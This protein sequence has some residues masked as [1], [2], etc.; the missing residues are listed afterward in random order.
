MASEVKQK[1][2]VIMPFSET[3]EK[4]TEDYWTN[5]YEK[6]LKPLIESG[7]PLI[8][9]RSSPLR[10]DILR[11]II[12][13][14]V[15]APIVVADLTDA[16]PNV[17]WELGV[18]QSFKHCTVTIAEN[19]TALPFDLGGKG[20]LF[21]FPSDYIKMQEF[22]DKFNQAIDDCLKNPDMPDSHVLE[23]ISGRGT[24]H[25]I[26]MRDESLRRLDALISEI[27]RN[28]EVLKD[29]L[30]YC[31]ANIKKRKEALAEGKKE[32]EAS[33]QIAT[34]RFCLA[35]VEMLIVSRY[36]DA[37][38]TFYEAA[39]KYMDELIRVNDQLPTWEVNAESFESW[40]LKV[41]ED[42]NSLMDKFSAL[43]IEHKK[44]IETIL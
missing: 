22:K 17:Y 1:C 42:T 8:A 24:L 38:K 25:Q 14:L 40:L 19:G 41:Q 43:V 2:F 39:E 5:H 37:D 34:G 7:H 30:D 23:T 9:E 28:A 44:A 15:T 6:F 18:R 12:T 4:H 11:Q 32:S 16:N 21:Y 29:T 33:T 3:I 35:A 26:L 13:D 10:G 20:T 36:I 31:N 27:E